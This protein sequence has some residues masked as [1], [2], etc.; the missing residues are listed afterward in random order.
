M[1][2]EIP[3]TP[4]LERFSERLELSGRAYSLEFSYNSR[5]GAWL[6]D[7]Y[8]DAEELIIAGLKLEEGLPMTLFFRG[9]TIDKLPEGDL[10]AL[11]K[12]GDRSDL[13]N[14]TLVYNDQSEV[15]IGT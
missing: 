7:I 14:W 10:V 9:N 13:G 2:W 15:Q 8:D 11:F 4:G 5:F 1:L 3:L 12:G 6:I